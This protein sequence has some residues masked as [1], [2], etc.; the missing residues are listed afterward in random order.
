M[1][2]HS[3][4]RQK[5]G[6]EPLGWYPAV[7]RARSL[8][9]DVVNVLDPVT[10]LVTEQPLDDDVVVEKDVVVGGVIKNVMDPRRFQLRRR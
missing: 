7:A 1:Q 8:A 4:S 2:K 3:G 6:K 10:A 9:Q 5:H